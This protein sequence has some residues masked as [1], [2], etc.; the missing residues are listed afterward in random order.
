MTSTLST[1]RRVPHYGGLTSSYH[2]FDKCL[3]GPSS[4][5][6]MSWT[7]LW[8]D[9]HPTLFSLLRLRESPQP[10]LRGQQLGVCRP[11]D[12]SPSR[13]SVRLSGR[14]SQRY[15]RRCLLYVVD[16]FLRDDF[17]RRHLA[18]VSGRSCRG[19]EGK[20]V[21]LGSMIGYQNEYKI[22]GFSGSLCHLLVGS[23]SKPSR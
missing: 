11:P 10:A 3:L 1:R 18:T 2:R 23:P 20:P 6:R 4:G 13:L 14:L 15:P 22:S 16:D 19:L 21:E 17:L 7:D 5:W 9:S 12:S 8:R